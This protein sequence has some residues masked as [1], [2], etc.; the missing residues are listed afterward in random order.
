MKSVVPFLTAIVIAGCASSTP[1]PTFYHCTIPPIPEY[2]TDFQSK[3]ADEL[4]EL[5]PAC[6]ANRPAEGCSAVARI[7][8][9]CG[10][11]R[12]RLR[13]LENVSRDNLSTDEQ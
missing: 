12:A 11:L 6:P 3:A 9:D 7:V 4:R 8:E 5:G 10:E 1:P 2:G 13:A